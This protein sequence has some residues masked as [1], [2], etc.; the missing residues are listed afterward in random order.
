[1][2]FWTGIFRGI[3]TLGRN[4]LPPEIS[5]IVLAGKLLIPAGKCLASIGGADKKLWL[6]RYLRENRINPRYPF[7]TTNPMESKLFLLARIDNEL[8][9]CPDLAVN[10]DINEVWHA[11]NII[12]VFSQIA[13]GKR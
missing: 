12:T 5:A 3:V 13:F 9:G 11:G 1:L 4:Q 7:F 2:A 10:F 6:C 8:Y